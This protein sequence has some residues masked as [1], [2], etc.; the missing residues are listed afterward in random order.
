MAARVGCAR[1]SA[2]RAAWRS[3]SLKALRM[4][5]RKPFGFGEVDAQHHATTQTHPPREGDT[6]RKPTQGTIIHKCHKIAVRGEKSTEI[7]AK[8][9]KTTHKNNSRERIPLRHPTQNLSR[10]SSKSSTEGALSGNGRG[11]RHASKQQEGRLEE[12]AAT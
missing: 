2:S 12:Q 9:V 1:P 5:V 3:A 11:A 8:G 7:A 6:A 10:I 4:S